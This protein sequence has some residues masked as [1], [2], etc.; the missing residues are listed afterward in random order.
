MY[1]RH[2]HIVLIVAVIQVFVEVVILILSSQQL[3][4]APQFVAR[5][6]DTRQRCYIGPVQA[7]RAT[8]YTGGNNGRD[9]SVV[10]FHAQRFCGHGF[11][12]RVNSRHIVLISTW[13]QSPVFVGG[14]V[15]FTQKAAVLIHAVACK[16]GL[17]GLIHR[18]GERDHSPQSLGVKAVRGVL[19]RDCGLGSFTWSGNAGA[20]HR[21]HLIAVATIDQIAVQIAGSADRIWSKY[22]IIAP[23]AVAQ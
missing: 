10:Q 5:D 17:Q 11:T 15:C 3:V 12:A 4:V 20:V 13:S 8:R 7:Y 6:H 16:I 21:C 2:F 1:I 19:Y 9:K 18:P 23:D 22:G 14:G